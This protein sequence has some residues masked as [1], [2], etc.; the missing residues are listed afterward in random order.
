MTAGRNEAFSR[1]LIDNA[2][3]ASKWDL[4]DPQQVR[5]ERNEDDR[6]QHG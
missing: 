2:L 5:F 1:I 6:P 3:T 4:L